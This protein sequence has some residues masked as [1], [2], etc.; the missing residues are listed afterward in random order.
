MN[1]TDA[2]KRIEVLRRELVRHQR[3]Y[4]GMDAPEISDA[5]YDSLMAELVRLEEAYPELDSRSSPSHRVG[6]AP[7]SSFQKVRHA[8]EQRSFDD[9]FDRDEMER[10]E[11]RNRKLLN[12]MGVAQSALSYDCELKI[13]GLKIVLTYE[14]GILVGAATRGDGSLGEDVT[15]NIRTV[16]SIPL[17]LSRPVTLIVGGEIWLSKRELSRINEE[18]SRAGAPLFANTRNAAAGSIRQLDSSV[19]A[20]RKLN[21]FIY[22]IEQLDPGDKRERETALS[23]GNEN[24]V[25]ETQTGEL[26]LLRELGF[27]VNQEFLVCRNLDEVEAYYQSWAKKRASLDYEIDGIVVKV[28]SLA[29]QELLGATGKSPRWGIAYKFPAE[30]VSTVVE[31]IVVQVGRTGTLTPVAHLRP[32]RVAGSTVSR[33]TLHNEDEVSRLDIR[34]GDTVILRKA[35]DVIPEIVRVLE[36]FR[37]GKE[38][39]FRMPSACPACGSAVSRIPIGQEKSNGKDRTPNAKR[40]LPHVKSESPVEGA[41][42]AARYCTNPLC[43]ATEREKII[44]A[45]GRKGFDIAGFGEKVAEQLF[46]IGMVSDISD[47]FALE[48]GD[49]EPLERFAKKSASKLAASIRRS[50]AVSFPK[51]LFALGIRHIGEETAHLIGSELRALAHRYSF[52]I[53]RGLPDIIRIFPNIRA[54]EWSA[55]KGIGEKAGSSLSSWFCD[56]GNLDRL[57]K[58]NRLGVAVTVELPEIVQSSSEVSG[59]TFVLTGELSRFT[60]D[61]A[62][63]MIRKRGGNVSSSVS[64][65]TDFLVAGGSPG[66]KLDKAKELDVRVLSE[67]E[68]V[69]MV[70]R[71]YF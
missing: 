38:K 68:F 15:D 36:A 56:R 5:A 61:E 25:G 58:M 64:R 37:T 29:F 44:H 42:S 62:K 1:H 10:W 71:Q 34:I 4:H 49:L 21:S 8:V 39:T 12:K 26:E 9:A 45:V 16:R 14:R 31:D 46:E 43:S 19:T 13:D 20:Q 57:R 69:E 48:E 65:K 67:E 30:E 70:G 22:D 41:M 24:R 50:R 32:V 53:P 3:L 63:D 51:F 47:V 33:A 54:E 66:S 2:T 7:L 40:R 35:G 11:E 60:R 52:E 17:E 18:R 59:K 6:S 28:E 55:I 27:R 23:A